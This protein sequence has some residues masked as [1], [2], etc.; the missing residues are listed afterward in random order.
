[1][2]RL[3]S[4]QTKGV[5]IGGIGVVAECVASVNNTEATLSA[6]VH[7][8]QIRV[9]LHQPKC[10]TDVVVGQVDLVSWVGDSEVVKTH[11]KFHLGSGEGEGWLIV[12]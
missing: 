5:K 6:R 7:G 1:M 12:R 10:S 3:L 11:Q 9:I 2:S 4:A 8:G